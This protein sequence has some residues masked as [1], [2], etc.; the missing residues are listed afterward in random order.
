MQLP[1]LI[2]FSHVRWGFVYQR[3]QH[4]MSRLA[5]HWRVLFVEEPV[6]DSKAA[7]LEE[8]WLD[9][10]LTVLVPHTPLPEPGFDG[11]QQPVMQRLL[12]KYLQQRGQPVDVAWL[13]TP[14]AWPLA[15][16][17]RPACVIYD[18]MEDVSAGGTLSESIEQ[19]ELDLLG[20]AT[21][22]LTD[23]PSLY[24]AR[25][26]QHPSVVCLPSAVD[27][28]HY[29]PDHLHPGSAQ[30]RHARALQEALPR[31]RLGFFGVINERFDAELLAEL[32][33]AHPQ[34]SLIMAGPVAGIDTATL[35]HRP[36][37]HWLGLQPYARLPYLLAGWDLCLM[38][39]KVNDST[40]CINPIKTLE[41]MAGGKPVVSTPIHD[42]VWMHSDAV[43][44]APRGRA[45]VQSCERLLAESP[46]D[47]SQRELAML[48]AVSASSWDRTTHAVNEL[49]L[50]AL[51]EARAQL[52]AT[53]LGYLPQAMASAR[54]A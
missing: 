16:T 41:Y 1:L 22:V 24:E 4:L 33:D 47:R 25:R 5:R 48:A 31:P 18:C 27:A 12:A 15:R 36:N 46:A 26:D 34:W 54:R 51:R 44:I 53:P 20:H 29:A 40:R 23:G 30:A 11:E 45:F 7:W 35:P 6:H 2:V 10:H 17:L 52:M 49:L 43:A 3:P 28:V 42:V 37:I 8:Q 50:K 13:S 14:M 39:Y 32:A 9:K 38:P 21:L 19:S